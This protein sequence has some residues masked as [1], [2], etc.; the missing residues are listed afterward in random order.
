MTVIMEKLQ[1]RNRIEVVL[2]AKPLI[3]N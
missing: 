1:D 2:K 3:D